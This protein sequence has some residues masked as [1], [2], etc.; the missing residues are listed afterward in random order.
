M[1]YDTTSYIDP[2]ERVP[3]FHDAH[4]RVTWTPHKGE[5]A[6]TVIGDY[7]DGD[8]LSGTVTLGCGIEQLLDDIGIADLL[9]ADH[10]LAV[11]DLVNRQLAD[12]PWAQVKCAQGTARIELAPM[13]PRV[14]G[15]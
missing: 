14:V 12:R 2:A 13:S 7:L 10:V 8:S 9:D 4:C 5:F 1:T 3:G 15:V 6:H 11:C